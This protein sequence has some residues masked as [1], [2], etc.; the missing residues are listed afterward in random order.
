MLPISAS[1]PPTMMIQMPMPVLAATVKSTP[2]AAAAYLEDCL[3]HWEE[4][5]FGLWALR[6]ADG[7]CA[8]RAGLRRPL[9]GRAGLVALVL[10]RL[11][12]RA[13]DGGG[14]VAL[15]LDGGQRA[16]VTLDR[17]RLAALG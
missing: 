8:G 6:T 11:A 3:P 13:L 9:A 15:A 12:R 2:E 5:G 16:S 1:A 7:R 4:H 10:G 17:R 14:E